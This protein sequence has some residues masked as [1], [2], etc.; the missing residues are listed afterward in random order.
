M[1]DSLTAIITFA[2]MLFSTAVVIIYGFNFIRTADNVEKGENYEHGRIVDTLELKTIREHLDDNVILND[3]E[4]DTE[5]LPQEE[6]DAI[7]VYGNTLKQAILLN[8]DRINFSIEHGGSDV[9]LEAVEYENVYVVCIN[10]TYHNSLKLWKGESI[11]TVRFK[12][13]GRRK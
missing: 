7:K 11:S 12:K 13:I 3:V 1:K 2:T 4:L 5:P 9:P 10:G 6:K 8:E